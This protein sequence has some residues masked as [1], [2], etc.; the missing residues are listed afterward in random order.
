ML[1]EI[2]TVTP[3]VVTW[4]LAHKDILLSL[5]GGATGL[6]VVAQVVL[7][8]LGSRL[9]AIDPVKRKVYSLLLAQGLTALAALA[10]QLAGNVNF[11]HLYPELATVVLFVHQIAVNPV[12]VKTVLPFLQYQASKTPDTNLVETI[13]TPQSTSVS[14]V[15]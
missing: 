12:Y 3:Q 9:D 15:G 13:D 7:H 2:Q 1:Q 4:V 6:S 11:L 14:F 5:V 8:K 10:T